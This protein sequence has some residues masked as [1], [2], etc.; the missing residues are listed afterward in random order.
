MNILEVA[1]TYGLEQE[2]KLGDI[3]ELKKI[4]TPVI[5]H[6]V[7][8]KIGEHMRMVFD[9]DYLCDLYP[10]FDPF[11]H[12]YDE[13]G[14]EYFYIRGTSK[15]IKSEIEYIHQG[16]GGH[17]MSSRGKLYMYRAILPPLDY[18]EVIPLHNT[19]GESLLEQVKAQKYSDITHYVD[20]FYLQRTDYSSDEES[21]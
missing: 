18:E 16:S 19:I 20:T 14:Y 21:I 17:F 11:E 8:E 9:E 10:S 15:Y 1:K 6:M 3:P 4:L 7:Q 2:V 13:Y 5:L 12:L